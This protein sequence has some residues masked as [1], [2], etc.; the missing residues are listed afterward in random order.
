MARKYQQYRKQLLD[1]WD[2]LFSDPKLK[3]VCLPDFFFDILVF[4]H[5]D[6]DL[7]LKDIDEVVSRHGGNYRLSDQIF[8]PGGNAGNLAVV[9]GA[10]GL[11]PTFI[12][13]VSSFGKNIIE[14][15][16]EPH[17]VELAIRTTGVMP[18]TVAFEFKH[19]GNVSNVMV[20]ANLDTLANF[21]SEQLD[22]FQWNHIEKANIIAVTNFSANNRYLDLLKGIAEKMSSTASF[23][24]DF[25][26]ISHRLDQMDE[27]HSVLSD[28]E[29]K[30]G[31]IS[32]NEN[33]VTY[34][35]YGDLH[36]NDSL[37][38]GIVLS[39]CFQEITFL[40]HTAKF[41]SEILNG[42]LIAKAPSLQIKPLR[43][44]G[45]GDT[46]NAGYLAAVNKLD[47]NKRLFFANTC[48]AYRM[49]TEKLPTQHNLKNYLKSVI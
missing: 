16:M 28:L 23:F 8:S 20:N 7:F 26:D 48:A 46:W 37:E 10:L 1:Q 45:A 42:S 2:S 6:Y 5:K 31:Y 15:F 22:K 13:N 38:T 39:K 21:G 49:V 9:L 24:L 34:L 4:P 29:A 44:T 14:H 47:A 40:I 12:T 30:I 17:N 19:A 33:E 11:R 18:S 43:A 3:I 35:N 25:S 41:S 27:I 32:L 36:H